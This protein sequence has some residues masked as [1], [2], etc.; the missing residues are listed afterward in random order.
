MLPK[1]YV[2]GNLSIDIIVGYFD[3]WPEVG[4]EVIGDFFDFRYTGAAGNT[5]NALRVLGFDTAVVSVVGDDTFGR[6]FIGDLRGRGI[7]VSKCRVVPEKTSVSVGISMRS[8]ERS[9][10]TYLGSLGL[11][12]RGFLMESIS[13]IEESWVVVCGFNLIP[14]FQEDSFLNVIE[15]LV[16]NGN[17]ILFDPGW[18]PGGWGDKET[19]LV[20]DIARKSAIFLPNQNEALAISR[21]SALDSALEY[22]RSEGLNGCIVKLGGDGARGFVGE[23]DVSTPAYRF[24][25]IVDT[26]GAGD[27]FNAALLRGIVEGWSY[28]EAVSFASFYSSYAITKRQEARYPRFEDIYPLFLK[29]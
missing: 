23:E 20:V 21:T 2:L 17:R 26:V 15:H 28:S 27:M 8:S 24:G 6:E 4:T 29:R 22:F 16:W 7:D 9:F 18:F 25:E 12:D 11:M 19:A 14:S 3:G 1:V 13:D 10:F 5:A